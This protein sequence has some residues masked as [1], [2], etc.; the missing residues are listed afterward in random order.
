M[1]HKTWTLL[2]AVLGSSVVFLDSAVLT[3]AL[4]AIGREP[5]LFLDVLEA[6]NYIQFG[7]LLSLSALLVLAGAL[8]DYFGRRRMFVIGLIGFGVTSLLCAIAPNLEVLIL[9]RIVQGAAGAI[10]VPGSLAILTTNFEGEEQGRAF[11]IWAAASGVAPIFGPLVGGLLVDN[12]SWRWIFLLNIPLTLLAV[13]AALRHVKESRDEH[14]SGNFDWIG[15]LL[16]ALA[17][18]G[19]SFGAIYGQQRQWKDPIAWAALG[20]GAVCVIALPFYFRWKKNPLVPLGM[21]RARNFSVTNVSTLLIYGA[22]YVA[23]FYLPLFTQG[24]LLYSA[25]AI[26]LGSI[27]GTLFLIFLSTRWGALAARRGPRWFMTVGPLFMAAAL[28]WAARIPPDSMPWHLELGNSASWLPPAAYWTDL[29]PSYIVFGLGISIM[30]APLTTALMRSVP[31]RQA[32]LASA[33]NNAISR[34]GPQLAGAVI[35]I[36]IAGSFYSALAARVPGL[37]VNSVE[38]RGNYS[39]L[40][41]PPASADE[42]T[43]EAV[44]DASTDAFHMAMLAAAGL[45]VA[46]AAVNGLFISDR[47]ALA[48]AEGPA[49]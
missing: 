38:V 21:F 19:L 2:A 5:R 37:D 15:A 23:F 35:F 10:L 20:L 1:T 18:G 28:L 17:V 12:L 45:L 24:T 26:G 49:T 40:N 34:V 44:H 31:G 36:I 39:P 9:T 3:V 43:I 16:V 8:S 4:P 46:G 14:A 29:F 42:A 13:Y 11:G 22:L 48:G 33:I 27:P 6:Q 41:P 47:Q 30:V 32:G 25:T 7:Y